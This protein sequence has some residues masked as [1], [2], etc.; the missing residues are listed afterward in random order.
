MRPFWHPLSTVLLDEPPCYATEALV[1]LLLRSAGEIVVVYAGDRM[2]PALR[3]GARIRVRSERGGLARGAI[4][5]ACPDG[6]PDL[7][8]IRAAAGS[9]VAVSA[10]ADPGAAFEL[11]AEAVLGVAVHEGGARGARVP[12]LLRAGLD[13][14]EAWHG[15]PDAAA[16]TEDRAATVRAKYD[17]QAPHYARD[18]DQDADPA[19]M[20]RVRERADAGGRVLVVGSGAGRECSA[21]ARNG[22]RVTGIDF[23]PR[24][25]DM[26]RA[27][28]AR[29]GLDVEFVAADIRSWTAGPAAFAGVL[30]T[31]DVYSFLPGRE[32][33]VA[34]L[35]ALRSSLAPGGVVLLS[36]R[37]IRGT[38]ART[39]LAIQWL[40]G[41]RR[42][43]IGEW[44]DSHTRW[45]ASD[46]TLRR[47][48]VRLFTEP[49]LS[50]EAGLAGFAMEPWFGGHA[51]LAPTAGRAPES[52]VP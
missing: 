44:G 30:F 43:G 5:L 27:D 37:R 47:S 52:R 48:F 26:A 28:A 3:H 38:W 19:L 18:A 45:V 39:V 40:S 25:V 16:P 21:L 6:I 24:M 33:R 35:R 42:G 14:R 32:T 9:R 15:A 34:V 36:A 13:L 20:A 29:R 2:W 17:D 7:L 31:Y 50:R 51:V 41:R 10:D 22:F 11:P 49:E 8:R 4:V 1:R 46:G 12:G 23:A